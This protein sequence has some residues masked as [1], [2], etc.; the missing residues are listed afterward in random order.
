MKPSGFGV[1]RCQEIAPALYTPVGYRKV[2]AARSESS[3]RFYK[4]E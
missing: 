4:R 2:F 3:P 1:L